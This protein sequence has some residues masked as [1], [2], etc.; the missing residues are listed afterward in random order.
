LEKIYITHS[1]LANTCADSSDALYCTER[2]NRGFKVLYLV[3]IILP[4]LAIVLSGKPF[5]A[6]FSLILLIF[7]LLIF[8]GSFGVAAG[9]H[10]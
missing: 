5:Q 8:I 6:I 2:L 3:A 7:S 4:P 10:S 1:G 9:S